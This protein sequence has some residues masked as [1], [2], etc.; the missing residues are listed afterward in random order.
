M[1]KFTDHVS[2]VAWISRPENFEENATKLARLADAHMVRFERRDM[3]FAMYISWEAGL[4]IVAP[5]EQQTE[6]NQAL[7]TWLETHGEG[8]FSVVF[9]IRELEKHRQ[10]IVA[11]GYE[12]GPL[13]HD[14][15]QS[16]WHDKLHRYDSSMVLRDGDPASFLGTC[17]I[18]GDIDYADGVVSFGDA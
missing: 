3:G 6:F 11:L 7:Y 8:V 2:H 4:E 18:L 16:P 5:L 9:G 14:H 17:F 1:K 10:R 12:A 13:M 15:P